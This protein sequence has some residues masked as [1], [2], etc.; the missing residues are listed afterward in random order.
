MIFMSLGKVVRAFLG[1]APLWRPCLAATWRA[2]TAALVLSASLQ[3]GA[4]QAEDAVQSV[5]R[6]YVETIAAASDP[7]Q[8]AAGLAASV[9]LQAVAVK[10]LSEAYT[11]APAADQ[12]DFNQLL[13]EI[14]AA[15]L[16]RRIRSEYGFEILRARQ[17]QTGDVVV[18]SRLTETDGVE[19]QLDWK[20]RPC[21]TQFCIYDLLSNNASFSA[22]LRND[23]TG[24]LAAAGG[25][26]AQLNL[27]LRAEMNKQ[28]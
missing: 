19:K 4:A 5:N 23:L 1:R 27:S 8:L 14:I 3:A 26:V 20:M 18:F 15:E 10:T 28:N 22:S 13:L 2:A 7:G 25:S 17:L 6:I 11:S 24:R 9:D 21:G 12:A 16:S